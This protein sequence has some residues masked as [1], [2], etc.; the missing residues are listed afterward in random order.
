MKKPNTDIDYLHP[1]GKPRSESKRR[2]F[3]NELEEEQ[4]NK[5]LALEE[6][7]G[8]H[9]CS[10]ECRRRHNLTVEEKDEGRFDS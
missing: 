8:H 6:A 5:K 9:I 2:S 10:D 1:Q 7:D 3:E 4:K